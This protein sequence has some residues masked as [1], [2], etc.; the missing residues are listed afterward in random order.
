[1]NIKNYENNAKNN[2]DETRTIINK[3]FI[4]LKALLPCYHTSWPSQ[5]EYIAAK[6]LWLDTFI[7]MK[8]DKWETIQHGLKKLRNSGTKYVPSVMEFINL[9]KRT[10]QELGIPS[11]EEAYNEACRN[12]PAYV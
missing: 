11:L 10:P 1:M 12:A 5:E 3:L 4:Q 7:E 8:I 6:R 9:C 2:E